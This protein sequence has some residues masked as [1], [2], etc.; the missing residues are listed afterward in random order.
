MNCKISYLAYR[1]PLDH[2]YETFDDI[3]R[4]SK[5]HSRQLIIFY[6]S[7]FCQK[8]KKLQSQQKII[9]TINTDSLC[10]PYRPGRIVCLSHQTAEIFN[11]IRYR[12]KKFKKSVKKTLT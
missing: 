2:I 5:I 7:V 4:I 1:V 11:K 8:K 9:Y 6:F 10:Y 3:F 12:Q